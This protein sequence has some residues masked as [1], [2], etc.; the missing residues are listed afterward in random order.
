MHTGLSPEW[1]R[2]FDEAFTDL[3]SHDD[4]LV[5]AEFTGLIQRSWPTRSSPEDT[6]GAKSGSASDVTVGSEG[7]L[8]CRPS[9]RRVVHVPDT[10]GYTHFMTTFVPGDKV[11]WKS[12]GR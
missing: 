1:D 3:V 2:R 4:D 9:P 8:G 12:H 10:H 6:T 7:V 11:T 5:R